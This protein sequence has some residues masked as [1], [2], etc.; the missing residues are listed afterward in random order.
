MKCRQSNYEI[1]E[2]FC[3]YA[4]YYEADTDSHSPPPLQ[5]DDHIIIF[6]FCT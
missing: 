1:T 3:G 5:G 6:R 2:P 4:G